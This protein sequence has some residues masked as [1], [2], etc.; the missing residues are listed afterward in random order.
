MK[1]TNTLIL[2]LILTLSTYS[3]ITINIED[4]TLR[5]ELGDTLSYREANGITVD[6][7]SYGETTWDFSGLEM[8]SKIFVEFI[9]ASPTPFANLYPDA[10]VVSHQV[11]TGE[12]PSD[13][14]GYMS[15]SDSSVVYY[16]ESI[17][18]NSGAFHIMYNPEREMF[19]PLSFDSS[20]TYE[21]TE[22]FDFGGD[23]DVSPITITN[24]VN[25]FGT[26]TLPG[27]KIIDALLLRSHE[28]RD[29]DGFIDTTKTFVFLTNE[30]D[31]ILLFMGSGEPD[32]GEVNVGSFIWYEN[33]VSG[34]KD[35]EPLAKEY[36]LKQNYPNPFNPS[37]KIEYSLPEANNVELKIYDSLGKQV[38]VL[39]NEFKSAGSYMVEFN[40]VDLASGI[41]FARFKSGD[42]SRSIKLTLLK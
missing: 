1:K 8:S 41:Y 24:N 3:Q 6:L 19:F 37:T 18:D 10:T 40:A 11:V 31:I 32:T 35:D 12:F 9:D 25:S 27:G 13:I 15:V 30:A 33:F 16:G 23:V 2:L 5:G 7:G 38:T 26:L 36:L 39:V 17:S 20:W 21:G 4:Y 42:Y 29:Y 34:T 14:Y 22:S 28:I